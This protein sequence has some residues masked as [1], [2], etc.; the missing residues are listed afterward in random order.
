MKRFK[1]TFIVTV[2]ALILF[3]N[4]LVASAATM[5]TVKPGESLWTIARKYGT[6]V[7][8]IKSTNNHWS[9][10]IHAGQTLNIPQ[11]TKYTT[12]HFSSR[13]L[14]LLA[15]LVHGEARGET[16]EGQVGVAAV[17]L[18][19]VENPKF[20]NTVSG[21][22]YENLAFESIMNGQANLRPNQETIK[23]AKAALNGWD[24]TGNSLFFYNPAK[25]HS[26]SNWIWTR[27]VVKNIGSHSF[28]V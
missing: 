16:F 7:N 12:N 25:I 15:R 1:I 2:V 9:E 10:L 27:R 22:I 4:V 3:T 14:D 20:P 19:R 17:I 23:A 18:N 28:A 11:K 13:D 24:P 8:Q 21:V 26:S 5:H 6:T